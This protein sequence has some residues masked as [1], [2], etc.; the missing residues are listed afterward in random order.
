M[1]GREAMTGLALFLWC[2]A[3]RAPTL[4][5]SVIDWD[6]SLYVI[7]A[8]QWARGHGPYTTVWDHKPIGVYFIFRLALAFW[9]SVAS[10]RIVCTV[11]IFLGALLIRELARALRGDDK[12]GLVAAVCYPAMSLALD[13]TAA[14]TEHFFMP[15][16]LLGA[17]VLLRGCSDSRT[18][19]P[20]FTAVAA[21]SLAFSPSP[22][23][24]FSTRRRMGWLT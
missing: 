22:G 11:F 16:T 8:D 9:R 17:W 23:A 15:F 1:I 19:W 13:G 12:A 4:Q 21:A 20:G 3:L 7:M 6:E 18:G 14:N 2:F 24:C 10:L 5:R